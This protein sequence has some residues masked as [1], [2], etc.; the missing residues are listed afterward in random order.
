L[1]TQAF[2]ALTKNE[3][4]WFP[5]LLRYARNDEQY[6]TSEEQSDEAI[7]TNWHLG[8]GHLAHVSDS[9]E[10]SAYKKQVVYLA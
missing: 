8:C 6:V 2:L 4:S 5:G 1:V 10:L 7:Q 9:G 3:L